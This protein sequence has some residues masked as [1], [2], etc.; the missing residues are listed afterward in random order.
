MFNS[1]NNPHRRKTNN[2]MPGLSFVWIADFST[3]RIEQ[4]VGETEYRF[5]EVIDRF[6]DLHLFHL[7]NHR[8]DIKITVDVKTGTIKYNSVDVADSKTEKQNI[9][10]I[11]FRRH[12][13]QLNPQCQEEAH[14]MYYFL[15]YQ[16]NDKLG[17]NRQIV[18]KIDEDGNFIIEE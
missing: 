2:A 15:G 5:Q 16:Y 10:L 3:T 11:Y 6:D 17:K 13:V 1:M 9:R 14:V 12:I 4:F 7:Y 18:L 8:K